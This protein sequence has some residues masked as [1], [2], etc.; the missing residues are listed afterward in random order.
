MYFYGSNG[1]SIRSPYGT[2]GDITISGGIVTAWGMK[3]SAGIGTGL[4]G[5]CG[6]ITITDKVTSVTAYRRESTDFT[7]G[8]SIDNNN[9]FICGT[10]KIGGTTYYSSTFKNDGKKYLASN[11]FVYKPTQ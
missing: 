11:P 7:I 2:C 8:K 9:S 5:S 3:S 6:D 1:H 10:V 4:R